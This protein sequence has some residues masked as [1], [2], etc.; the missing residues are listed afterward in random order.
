AGELEAA[1]KSDIDSDHRALIERFDVALSMILKT[2]SLILSLKTDDEIVVNQSAG[3]QR[4]ATQLN[5]F[6]KRLEPFVQKK[7][8]KPCKEIMEEI[9]ALSW[10]DGLKS[11]LGELDRLIGKYNFKEALE[12]VEQLKS[13]L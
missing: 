9:N 1:F 11:K 5:E 8:P 10:S 7:K 4:D 3:K 2:L 12:I 13:N 6:L